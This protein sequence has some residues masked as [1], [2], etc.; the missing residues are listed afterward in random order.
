MV[1]EFISTVLCSRT[2]SKNHIHFI[3][4]T[5]ARGDR[6]SHQTTCCAREMVLMNLNPL[7]Y[8]LKCQSITINVVTTVAAFCCNP[9][10]EHIRGV[11]SD[12]YVGGSLRTFHTSFCSQEQS[13]EDSRHFLVR[14]HNLVYKHIFYRI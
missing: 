9:S 8:I 2:F 13:I 7:N 12:I 5:E 3:A 1:D 11:S 6:Y 4:Y 10:V 14:I